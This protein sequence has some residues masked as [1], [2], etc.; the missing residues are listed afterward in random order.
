[1]ELV[2]LRSLVS[3]KV[4]VISMEQMQLNLNAG[5]AARQLSGFAL[6]LLISVNHAIKELVV[7]KL[8]IAKDQIN[9]LLEEN[10]QQMEMNILWV[11]GCAEIM[12]M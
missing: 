7:T 2:L 1:M 5:I 10:I 6:A 4:A 9:V 12:Q 8:R 11:V 3:D